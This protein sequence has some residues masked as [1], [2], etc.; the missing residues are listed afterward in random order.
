[1][2]Q[3]NWSKVG[4]YASLVVAFLIAGFSALGDTVPYASAI[5]AVLTALA[6]VL[7]RPAVNNAV[8]GALKAGSCCG[9]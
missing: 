3:I 1:M 4:V 8:A 7:H 5:L 9:K 6:A 2:N